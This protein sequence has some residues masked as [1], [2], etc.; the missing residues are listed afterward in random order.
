M[1]GEPMRGLKDKRILITGGASGIGAATAARFLEEGSRVCVLDRDDAACKRIKHELSGLGEAIIAD[2]TDLM[3]VEAAFAEA[4]RLMDGIDVVVNNAGISIRHKFLE[5]TPEEW[6]RVI[7]VNLTGVF[8][9]AQTAARYMWEQGAGVILQTASTNGLMGYPFYADYNA[10]KAGV[11]ELTKS[12][13]LELAPKIRVCAIAPGYVLTPM[14]RAEYSDAM[15][16]EVNAK[17]PMRRHASP[18]E[19]AGLFA[20]L[21][22]DDAAF[23]TG[24]VFTLDGGET[25]GGLAS[26]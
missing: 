9:V 11:I 12:M 22:S 13:A 25:A 23:A 4:I 1:Q 2:V 7:A 5:I 6:D 18:E 14:Q 15:L 17:V 21:A 26:R 10:T 24:Q 3:Q 8:Y 20:Y 19:I 16:A